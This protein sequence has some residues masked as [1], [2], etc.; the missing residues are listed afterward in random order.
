VSYKF[1]LK[2]EIK[3]TLWHI[4]GGAL[5]AYALVPVYGL[6]IMIL[7]TFL[8]GAVRELLQFL[9]GKEQAFYIIVVDVLSWVVGCLLWFFVRNYFNINADIL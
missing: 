9:R 4:A 6:W 7:V 5:I 2:K 3:N 1:E 8:F